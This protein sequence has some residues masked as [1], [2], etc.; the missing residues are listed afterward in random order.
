MSAITLVEIDAVAA[1]NLAAALR[2]GLDGCAVNVLESGTASASID[3]HEVDAVVFGPGIDV[4]SALALARDLISR[5]SE[6]PVVLVTRV[7]ST[8]LMR[9]ALRAGLSDV[10]SLQEQGPA[11]VVAAVRDA[12]DRMPSVGGRPAEGESPARATVVTILSTKGGVGKSVIASNLAVALARTSRVVLVDLDLRSGDIAIMLSIKPQ[13]TIAEAAMQADRLDREMLGGF[14]ADHDSGAKVLLAPMIPEDADAVTSPRLSKILDLLAEMFEFVIIDTPPVLE[15]TVITAV[16][17]SDRVFVVATMDVASVKDT[18]ISL[19]RLR[20]LGYGNG[21][22]RLLLNRAD[23]KV[24]LEP[25]DIVKSVGLP[26]FARIP[27]DRLVP[28]SVNKGVPVVTE[29]PRSAVSKSLVDIA[30]TV[31]GEVGGAN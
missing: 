11:D 18:R 2:G 9:S 7:A 28:R 19:Q 30:H 22:V 4:D 13:Q 24:W 23:S 6:L 3:V 15:D 1:G 25:S 14:L 16:D 21:S 5:R 12:L 26:I 17:K 27:S 29:A 20:T 10:V 8:E 31:V